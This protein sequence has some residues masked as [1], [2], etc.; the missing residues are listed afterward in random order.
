MREAVRLAPN[1][2]FYHGELGWTYE[3]KGDLDSAILEFEEAMRLFPG[4]DYWKPYAS[5]AARM[6]ELLPLL[7]D[8]I[9]G[10][11]QPKT[12]D[13]ATVM[14]LCCAL[15]FQ[16][17]YACSVRLYE[18]A[19]K[20][21][22]KLAD[23]MVIQHRWYAACYAARAAR[24]DGV[25]A[26]Q[27]PIERA[28]LRNLAYAWLRADLTIHVKKATSSSRPDRNNV[29]DQLNEWLHETEIRELRAPKLLEKL[30]ADESKK[31]LAFWDEV[32]ATFDAAQRANRL[33]AGE[34]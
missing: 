5:R 20:E 33:T 2:P 9:A 16:N 28:R 13:D 17:R 24:G 30:P 1:N 21:D 3:Y 27:D 29:L 18:R 32:R 26:P 19:F 11:T 31:W 25:D 4:S 8:V 15:P 6:K 34:R 7:K 14:A 12:P 22:P 10:Q 23:D